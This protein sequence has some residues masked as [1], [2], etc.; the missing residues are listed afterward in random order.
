MGTRPLRIGYVVKRFPRVSETFIAQEIIELERR[1]AEVSVLTLGVNDEPAAH[2]WLGGL[3]AEVRLLSQPFADAW[4]EL[5]ARYRVPDSQRNAARAVLN[6]L[7]DPMQRGHRALSQAVEIARLAEAGKIDH[8]HAH[9]ANQPAMT[10][11]L[12]HQ[13]CGVPFSVT[14]HAKDIWT[15]PGGPA[16]WRRLARAASFIVTVSDM[17]R[18]HVA[19]LVGE[20]L[21]SSVRR[22]YNGIDLAALQPGA[23]R[24]TDS[25]E[26]RLLCVARQVEKKGLDTLLDACGLLQRQGVAFRLDLFGDGQLA[27]LLRRQAAAL[28]LDGRVT[29]RGAVA[30]EQVV[31]AMQASDVFV[32]PCRVAADGDMDTLP[33]VLLEAMACGLP[34]ISTPIVGIGEIVER[35]VTGEL[36]PPADAPKLAEAIELLLRDPVN[37]MRMGQAGRIRAAQYFDRRKNV[38]V[39]HDWFCESLKSSGSGSPAPAMRHSA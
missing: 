24:L 19:K 22:L 36:V 12:A 29:F 2:A 6:A 5:A 26:A 16:Y 32:L 35:G 25:A 38:A 27:P 37:R 30:H 20:P 39:L 11:L 31:A 1:G 3:R 34:C 4:T 10:T 21:A 28:G 13:L 23:V 17:T 14:A 7:S 8:L 9:F 18:R 15:N 33:T